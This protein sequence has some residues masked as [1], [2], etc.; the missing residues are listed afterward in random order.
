MSRFKHAV[1]F[2]T[3][4]ISS[5]VFL[6]QS[7]AVSRNPSVDEP[8][9]EEVARYYVVIADTN[10]S[11]WQVHSTMMAFQQTS[12]QEIDTMGRYFNENANSLML[13]E[14]DEDEIYRGGYYPRRHPSTVLSIEYLETYREESLATTFACVVGIYENEHDARL[15]VK[16][17]KST[18]PKIYSQQADIYVGCMH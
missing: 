9:P 6:V 16:K 7:C 2:T 18:F 3:L 17:W 1:L 15:A 8:L 12:G 11:Y 13:P 14:D 10:Q 4:L 5:V